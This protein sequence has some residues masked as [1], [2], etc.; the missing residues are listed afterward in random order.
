MK[1]IIFSLIFV[2]FICA[3]VSCVSAAENPNINTYTDSPEDLGELKGQVDN[4][5]DITGQDL[6]LED[7]LEF[8]FMDNTA[9]Y[10]DDI[11]VDN[12]AEHHDAGEI[13]DVE[14]NKNTSDNVKH[15]ADTHY[16]KDT[17]FIIVSMIFNALNFRNFPDFFHFF[18]VS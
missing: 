13:Q 17:F 2:L 16:R 9:E 6:L 3:S 10:S 18:F 12:Y 8:Q 5:E 7:I 15:I 14:L 1:K 4:L 11:I